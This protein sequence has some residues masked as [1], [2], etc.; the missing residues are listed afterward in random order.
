MDVWPT[1]DYERSR[2]GIDDLRYVSTLE[3]FI[4][5]SKMSGTAQA[6]SS[7][8]EAY[9]KQVEA[10]MIPDWTAYSDGGMHWPVDGQAEVDPAKAAAIGSLNTLRRGVADHVLAIQTAM[11]SSEK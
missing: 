4:A 5:K 8:A 9:L 1:I 6:E 11:G 2:E 3:K 7:A 10:S